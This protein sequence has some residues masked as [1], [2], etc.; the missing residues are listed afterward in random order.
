MPVPL[1]PPAPCPDSPSQS[2]S[3]VTAQGK[4]PTWLDLPWLLVECYMYVR[5]ARAIQG[6]PKL[7]G[8]CGRLQ[9]DTALLLQLL[10]RCLAYACPPLLTHGSPCVRLAHVLSNV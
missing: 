9:L 3:Q 4:Q 1:Q 8:K 5:I 2:Q 7:A 6:Q 10:E